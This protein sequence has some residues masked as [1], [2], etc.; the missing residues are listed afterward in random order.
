MVAKKMRAAVVKSFAKPLSVEDVPVPEVV[1]GGV[2]VKLAACGVCHTDLHA[3]DGDWQFKPR[4]PL[5]PGHEG[6]GHVAAVPAGVRTV[7][8]GDRVG[9]PWLYTA[10]GHCKHCLTGW[11]T[12]CDNQQCTGY[13]INGCF[14]EYVWADPAYCTPLPAGLEW[15]PAAPILCAGVT[16][17]KGLKQTDARPGQ[18]V[19]ISGIGGLGHLAIQYAKA[20]GLHVIAV[21]VADEKLKLA[22][23]CGADHAID[24]RA[25]DP[26]AQVRKL[27]GG[28]DGVLVTAPSRPAFAQ[29]AGMLGKRGTMVLIGLPGGT[30]ELDIFDMVAGCKSIRGSSVGT[31]ADLAEAL[32]FAG[33]GKVKSHYTTD[34]LDNVNAVFDKMRRGAIEGRV[35]VTF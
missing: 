2:L 9:V 24:A 13:T 28:A 3:A 21:D 5:I 18:T 12:L 32:A 19:V 34:K 11:E 17:Y 6:V 1:P 30:F 26:V 7:K 4:L 22:K 8:E 20:M 16:V 33:E 31:R 29:G 15:A 27:C 25:G 23:R 14:A 35:V 10:C